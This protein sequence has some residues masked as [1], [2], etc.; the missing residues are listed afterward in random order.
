MQ[1]RDMWDLFNIGQF[2]PLKQMIPLSS[3]NCISKIVFQFCG[4]RATILSLHKKDIFVEI[5]SRQKTVT[6]LH[7]LNIR[8]EI[9]RK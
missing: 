4:I 3:V 8:S 9:N 7:K 5:Y 6:F 2:D 1:L